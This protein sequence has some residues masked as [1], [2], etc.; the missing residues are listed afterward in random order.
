MPVCPDNYVFSSKAL[1]RPKMSQSFLDL[2]PSEAKIYSLVRNFNK[3]NYRGARL[4]ISK[5]P[6]HVWASKLRNYDDRQLL[7][8]LQ[9]GW[10]VGYEGENIPCLNLGNHPSSTNYESHIDNYLSKEL[11]LGALK[12]P[13]P[14]SPFEWLRLNPLMTRPK[15]DSDNRR[16]ILDLSFPLGHSVNSE[17]N[18]NI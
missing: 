15:K 14:V 2:F 1:D 10:P 18:K 9:F 8:F 3:P 16:V 13:F 11:S 17:I 6:I 5:F 4:P 12:G 7:E